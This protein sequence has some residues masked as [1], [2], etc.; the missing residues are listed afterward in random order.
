MA[1]DVWRCLLALIVGQVLVSGVVWECLGVS[2]G[3]WKFLCDI[4]GYFLAAFGCLGE[5]MRARS[6]E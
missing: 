2:E 5:Y 3:V 4:Q 6:G 1:E